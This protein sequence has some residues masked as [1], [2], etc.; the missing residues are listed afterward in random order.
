MVFSQRSTAQL[1]RI[2]EILKNKQALSFVKKTLKESYKEFYFDYVNQIDD[3]VEDSFYLLL[4]SQSDGLDL[5]KLI[6]MS[7]LIKRQIF[8]NHDSSFWFNDI[9]KQYKLYIRPQKDLSLIKRHIKG[10][11]VLD[12][13]SGGGYLALAMHKAG[14][15]VYTADVLDYRIPDAVALPFVKM[16]NPLDV[17]FNNDSF[18]TVIVKTVLHHVDAKNLSMLVRKL[19]RVGKRIIVE[20]DTYDVPSYVSG[21]EKGLKEQPFLKEFLEMPKKTQL[22]SLS[23]LDYF[24]NAIVLGSFGVPEINFP[25]QFKT[26]EEWKQMFES[27]GAKLTNASLFGFSNGKM[28]KNCQA[29]MTFDRI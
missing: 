9:Y 10:K 3:M 2:C 18:D 19:V 20:E 1:T 28:H 17:P 15:N 21:L 29:W 12:F 14:F 26:V 4:L 7:D 22:E 6:R 16:K 5:D 25:F 23:L 13:G 8:H 27:A 24:A 11:K